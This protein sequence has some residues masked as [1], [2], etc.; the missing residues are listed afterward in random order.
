M[1]GSVNTGKSSI[2]T[3]DS[4][5]IYI[6]KQK[7]YIN[8]SLPEFVKIFALYFLFCIVIVIVVIVNVITIVVTVITI[9]RSSYS[10]Y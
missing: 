10:R 4:I 2:V 3:A 8:C 5:Y 1:Q 9:S 6:Q 7:K